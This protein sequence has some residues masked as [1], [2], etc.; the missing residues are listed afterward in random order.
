MKKFIKIGSGLLFVLIVI[1]GFGVIRGNAQSSSIVSV[2]PLRADIASFSSLIGVNKNEVSIPKGEKFFFYT[3]FKGGPIAGDK[4]VFVHLVDSDGITKFSQDIKLIIPTSQWWAGVNPVYSRIS[5]PDNLPLGKYKVMTGIYDGVNRIA[6]K[7]ETGV[8]SANQYRY[9][10]GTLNIHVKDIV[11]TDSQYNDYLKGKLV[12]CPIEYNC[13]LSYNSPNSDHF[14]LPLVI[15]KT[16]IPQTVVRGSSISIPMNFDIKSN[17]DFSNLV[18]KFFYLNYIFTDELGNNKTFDSSPVQVLFDHTFP[19]ALGKVS[20]PI[21]VNIPKDT[22]IGTYIVKVNSLWPLQ[23]TLSS[24][25]LLMGDQVREHYIKNP[26]QN[27]TVWNRQYEVGRINVVANETPPVVVNDIIK[28]QKSVFNKSATMGESTPFDLNFKTNKKVVNDY[29]IYLKLV[30]SK[31]LVILNVL[32]GP[33]KPTSSWNGSVKS[34]DNIIIPKIPTAPMV[35]TYKVIVGL[36]DKTKRIL[37]PLVPE[38]GVKKVSENINEYEVGSIVIKN[39]SLP[40]ITIN[41]LPNSPSASAGSV[42]PYSINFQGGPT[43][44]NHKVLVHFVDSTGNVK[45]QSDITPSTPTSN[46]KAGSNNWVSA[47]VEVPSNTPAG[48][49]RVMV[50]LYSG[51]T[52]LTLNPGSGVTQTD[53]SMYQIGTITINPFQTDSKPDIKDPSIIVPPVDT[54]PTD[55][56]KVTINQWRINGSNDATVANMTLSSDSFLNSIAFQINFQGGPTNTDKKMFL[57]VTDS[58]GNIKFSTDIFPS[59]P[60]SRWT[61]NSNNWISSEIEVPS[62]LSIGT[63]NVWAG[64]YSGSDRVKLKSGNGVIEDSQNRYKIGS[65]KIINN[66]IIF[67]FTKGIMTGSVLNAIARFFNY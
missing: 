28:I 45:F 64:L 67:N 43:S 29:N 44:V 59:T 27:L 20:V 54:P 10:I 60:T 49:Y 12:T 24:N 37:I 6:L 26:N 48:T 19:N 23:A 32:F 41:K 66:S 8:I 7:P 33:S 39:N 42:L 53:Q 21:T 31:G 38:S 5:L 2:F 36:Q 11:T 22:K 51:N 40:N 14:F 1:L 56:P 34:I 4:M 55:S 13:A 18:N 58:N 62:N 30:G 3:E 25:N 9:Q 35:D 65:I 46:W 47:G 15:E 16:I 17:I 61:S 63:Y 52:R 57:H 50:G